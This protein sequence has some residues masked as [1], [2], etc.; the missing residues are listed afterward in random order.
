MLM[1][2]MSYEHNRKWQVIAT[3]VT[4]F[5]LMKLAGGDGKM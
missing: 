2:L 1:S 3:T 5:Y 4:E